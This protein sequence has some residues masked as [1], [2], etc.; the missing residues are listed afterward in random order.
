MTRIY[1]DHNATSP[2]RP[3]VKEKLISC[4]NLSCGNPSSVHTSGRKIKSMLDDARENVAKLINANPLEII[5]TSSGVEANHLAWNAFSR[6]QKKILTSCIEHS[7]IQ[8][9]ILKAENQGALVTTLNINPC[10]GID[11]KHLEEALASK[12]HFVSIHHA[13][14]ETG[15]LYPILDIAK[16]AKAIG[17]YVHSDAVQSVGKTTIDVKDLAVDYLTLSGHKLGA[18]Q[19]VGAL[20][21]KKGSPLASLWPGSSQERGHRAGTEN[22]FGILSMGVA[23]QILSAG[24]TA[25]K[26][27]MESLRTFFEDGLK[28]AITGIQ[29]TGQTRERLPNTSHIIFDDV[30]AESLMIACDL[31][32]IDISTGSACSSGSMEASKVVTAMGIDPQRALGSARFSFGWNTTQEDITKALQV[33]PKL[34]KHIRHLKP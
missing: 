5:F 9:A 34:V 25:E 32:G 7:C 27:R 30:D 33:I 21:V 26:K 8:H 24:H 17:A 6:P 20:F 22:V 2:L 4:L 16:K 19:G 13:N 29:I 3:E 10:G 18:L 15:V 11:E 14:N 31:E 1:F 23:E 28:A 12:P